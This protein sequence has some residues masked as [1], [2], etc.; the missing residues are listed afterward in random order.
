MAAITPTLITNRLG[1]T[2]S[3]PVATTNTGPTTGDIGADGA[4]PTPSNLMRS[5]EITFT[6][7]GGTDAFNINKPTTLQRGL[8]CGIRLTPMNAAAFTALAAVTE[9]TTF[10]TITC[11]A[12]ATGAKFQ[13]ELNA[14][15]SAAR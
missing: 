2:T 7:T 6:S 11:G 14:F 4:T 15:Y 9:G 5:F 1:V 8:G 3:N 10:F 12:A 13:V